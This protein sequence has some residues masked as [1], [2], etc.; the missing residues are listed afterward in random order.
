VS[1]P[2]RE[3]ALRSRFAQAEWLTAEIAQLRDEW[4]LDRHPFLR[5]WIAGELTA[6]DLQL[7]AAEHHHAAMALEDVGR[8]AAALSDGLL[9]EQLVAYAE[10]QAQAVTQS[11]EFAAA[12][13]WGR[14]S[15]YFAQDPLDDTVTC[16]RAW[17]GQS[18]SLAGHLVTIHAVESSLGQLAP[19]QV[20]ALVEHYGFDMESVRYFTC[21]AEG[22]TGNA[23]LSA[24][25]L[26][27]LLPLVSPRVLVCQA[28]AVCRSYRGLLDGVQMLSERSTSR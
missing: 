25:A 15:W 5:R 18:S 22:A 17:A 1:Q 7:F 2:T 14:S 27:S 10:A 8:R 21:L 20:G 24:A 3:A 26:T 6:L 11:C 16:A 12:T 23:A 9:A 4:R 19:R 28:E 13:G